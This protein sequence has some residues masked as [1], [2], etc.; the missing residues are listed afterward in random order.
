MYAAQYEHENEEILGSVRAVF[1]INLIYDFLN[2][3]TENFY[4]I[5]E[6]LL[7]EI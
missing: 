3:F 2:E 1:P 5:I 7:M 6:K 4:V